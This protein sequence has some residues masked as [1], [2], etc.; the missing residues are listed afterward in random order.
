MYTLK[1][2]LGKGKNKGG[3][4]IFEENNVCSNNAFHNAMLRK[5]DL[6]IMKDCFIICF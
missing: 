4:K 3:T 2:T 6:N 1:K 5:I